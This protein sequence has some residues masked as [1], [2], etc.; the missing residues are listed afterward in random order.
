MY[1]GYFKEPGS[2]K[3]IFPSGSSTL[4]FN[5]NENKSINIT[6]DHHKPFV[7][8]PKDR[9]DEK[10]KDDFNKHSSKYKGYYFIFKLNTKYNKNSSNVYVAILSDGGKEININELDSS[11]K[12]DNYVYDFAG[13]AE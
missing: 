1:S 9:L 6:K 3:S 4:I 5:I 7:V 13:K 10:A 8:I 2:D 11:A 12:D